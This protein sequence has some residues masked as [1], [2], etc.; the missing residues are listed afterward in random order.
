VGWLT[1]RHPASAR[2]CARA[3]AELAEIRPFW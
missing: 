3:L 1:A 2:E